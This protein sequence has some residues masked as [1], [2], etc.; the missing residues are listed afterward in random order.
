M[1]RGGLLYCGRTSDLALE[2]APAE[3]HL[4]IR[5]QDDVYDE[6]LRPLLQLEDAPVGKVG[7]GRQDDLLEYLRLFAKLVDHPL[8]KNGLDQFLADYKK[9]NKD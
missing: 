1:L 9:A 7:T 2:A 6:G 5:L 4:T 3:R 8:T